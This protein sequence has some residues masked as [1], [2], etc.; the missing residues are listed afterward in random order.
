MQE[1]ESKA[2]RVLAV[3]PIEV[4]GNLVAGGHAAAGAILISEVRETALN[5]VANVEFRNAEALRTD[6]GIQTKS[7]RVDAGVAALL[8]LRE[9]VP[10]ETQRVD[11]VVV[12]L[13]HFAD[14]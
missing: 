1:I 14:G 4:I 8:E 7:G 13:M 2:Q 12:E 3:G 5:R 11:Q 6:A 10:T 9:A